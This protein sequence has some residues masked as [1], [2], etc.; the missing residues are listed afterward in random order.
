MWDYEQNIPFV[1]L[2]AQRFGNVTSK[3]ADNFNQGGL[4]C[5]I[6]LKTGA[7]GKGAS[8]PKNSQLLWH[9]VHPDTHS[10]IAGINIPHWEFT[11]TKIT[12]IANHIPYIPY[13]GWD[14]VITE[15]GF[16]IIEGNSAPV[17][18]TIQMHTPLLEDPRVRKFYKWHNII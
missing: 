8:F 18:R 10:Q 12:E 4:S 17:L 7:L 9:E 11:I 14:V 15:Q 3:P 2:A 13:I 5:S 1:A 16:K 6:D